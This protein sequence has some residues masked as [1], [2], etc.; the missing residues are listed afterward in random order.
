MN[1][2]PDIT[3][4]TRRNLLEAFW[5]LYE[6]KGLELITVKEIAARAGY[7]RGTFYEY[8]R[9]TR[10][11]LDQIEDLALPRRD[12][13]PPIP[14]DAAGGPDPV[15][16]FIALYQEKIRYYR[17][18]LGDRGDPAFQRKLVDRVK[19][20]LAGDPRL[21]DGADPV[22]LDVR[23]EYILAGMIGVLRYYFERRPGITQ[24]EL[25][26]IMHRVMDGAPVGPPRP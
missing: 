10:H 13:L 4:Q 6:E 15:G 7:N 3:E 9:D 12:E 24:R 19:A 2:K 21:P 5:S 23:L 8:F 1:R 25:I 20:V 14:G 11:C 16:S 18:L 22:E 26:G 17:L